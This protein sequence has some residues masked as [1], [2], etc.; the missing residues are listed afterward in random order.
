M[1]FLL[2]LLFLLLIVFLAH[3]ITGR[4]KQKVVFLITIN[5]EKKETMVEILKKF[6]LGNRNKK[7][8]IITK[9]SYGK[10]RKFV[11]LAKNLN[12]AKEIIK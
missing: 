6:P 12:E 11:V 1:K 3:R 5:L 2:K 9:F 4:K 10:T 8:R 7:S